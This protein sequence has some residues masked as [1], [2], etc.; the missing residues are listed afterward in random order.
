ML[1]TDVVRAYKRAE[2]KDTKIITEVLYLAPVLENDTFQ[3]L[4]IEFCHEVKKSILL[5]TTQLDGLARLL[6]GAKPKQ[7]K[8]DDLNNILML[9]ID[10]LQGTREESSKSIYQLLLATSCVLDS[11][12]DAEVEGIDRVRTHEPLLNY[13]KSLENKPESYLVY[14]AA[15]A[16]QALL[17]VPDN[18]K[19]WQ[20]GVRR[21][22]KVIQGVSGLVSAVKGLDLNMFVEGLG[23][24]RDGVDVVS[25]LIGNV[26]TLTKS[27]KDLMTSLKEGLSFDQKRKWYSAL[28][29]ADT[30]IRDGKLATFRELVYKVPCRSDPAFQWGVCQR[31]GEIAANP[32]WESDTRREAIVFLGEI[33]RNDAWGQLVDIKQ[34]ILDI[35]R[36]L[37]T[38]E[39]EMKGMSQS[40]DNDRCPF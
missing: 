29:G 13:L 31:L 18:E 8:V 26:V 34:W 36:Q 20:A 23:D 33:Y 25:K 3:D 37:S 4:L 6:Q 7:L 14:Q 9:L 27:G 39:N 28:R 22:G 11:M 16:Y 32:L 2:I 5:N 1:A 38:S 40:K 12:V 30:F 17:C 24:I 15:Y 19:K 35:L 10:R 21:A